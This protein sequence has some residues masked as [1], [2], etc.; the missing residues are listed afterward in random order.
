MKSYQAVVLLNRQVSKRYWHM[1]ID[2][3]KLNSPV[4]PGQFFHIRCSDN[5]SPFLRR[6]L[7]VYKVNDNTIE[8][9]YLVKGLGTKEM[10]F[11]EENETIDIMGPLGEGFH[12]ESTARTI[13]L[14]AR[15]VGVAT[16]AALAQAA[17]F[18]GTHCV[19]ILSARTNEDLLAADFLKGFGADVYSVTEEEGTSAVE[20]VK[21]LI[22]NEIFEKFKIDNI[23]T[24]GSK[25]LSRLAQEVAETYDIPGEIALEEHMGCAMGA[26][27]ACVSDIKEEGIVKSVRVC[28]E[29]P[30]FPLRKVLL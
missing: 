2:T 18:Q 21:G 28:I 11:I 17:Y 26:C 9:L 23:Y 5:Q 8:F 13:L 29:G 7:S 10:S 14:V 3:T 6:P 20:N 25:R 16:L 22:V 12:L 27:F 19:V 30:V 24:C 1:I 15:G 4:D